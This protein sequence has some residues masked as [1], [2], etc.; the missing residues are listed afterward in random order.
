M[1]FSVA[2][3]FGALIA[4]AVPGVRGFSPVHKPLPSISL[5]VLQSSATEEKV[6]ETKVGRKLFNYQRDLVIDS[7]LT[8]VSLFFLGTH[9]PRR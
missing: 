3:L 6:E 5:T 2:V 8:P 9:D 7:L 4:N 1:R